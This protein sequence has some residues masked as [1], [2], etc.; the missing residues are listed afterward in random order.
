[1]SETVTIDQLRESL[2]EILE[3]VQSSGTPITVVRDGETLA[4][5]V[6]PGDLVIHDKTVTPEEAKQIAIGLALSEAD[7]TAGRVVTLDEA[8]ER[9]RKLWEARGE[10]LQGHFHGFRARPT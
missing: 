5:I 1:M 4:Q 2:V 3:H 10:R 9:L 7:I 6:P 8:V